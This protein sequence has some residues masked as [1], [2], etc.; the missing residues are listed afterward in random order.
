MEPEGSLPCLQDPTT[1]PYPEPDESSPYL[2]THLPKIY[3]NIIIPSMVRSSEWPLPFRF[4]DHKF[5]CIFHLTT[6]ATC[7]AHL[8]I[9]DLITQ[10]TFGEAYKL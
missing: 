7:P 9:L 1:G 3:S 6:H 2:P 5:L 8:I 10:V 4:S